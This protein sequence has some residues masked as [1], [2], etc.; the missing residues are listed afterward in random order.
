MWSSVLQPH[1]FLLK[2]AGFLHSL[3]PWSL[4]FKYNIKNKILSA[5]IVRMCLNYHL[6]FLQSQAGA[7]M[8]DTISF[9][10]SRFSRRIFFAEIFLSFLFSFLWLTFLGG[11][12]SFQM[13][14][15]FGSFVYRKPLNL[16]SRGTFEWCEL[17]VLGK[18]WPLCPNWLSAE[19]KK[20][21]NTTCS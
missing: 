15:K 20:S 18:G 19:G 1:A 16:H 13:F 9:T 3:A 10:G 8:A 17:K 7:V 5:A 14:Y 4:S 6:N 2:S 21:A 12:P 11:E